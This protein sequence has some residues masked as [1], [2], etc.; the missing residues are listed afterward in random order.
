MS[1]IVKRGDGYALVLRPDCALAPRKY[2][3]HVSRIGGTS[4]G[5]GR[6]VPGFWSKV[7]KTGCAPGGCWEWIGYLDKDGYGKFTT[8]RGLDGV[9]LAKPRTFRPHRALWEHLRG[10]IPDDLYLLHNCDNARCVNPDHLRPGTQRENIVECYARGRHEQKGDNRGE[11]SG[12]AKLTADQVLFIRAQ[13]KANGV[14]VELSR[15]FGVSVCTLSQIRLR[16]SWKHIG[17]GNIANAMT[18]AQLRALADQRQ[19]E[20]ANVGHDADRD[21]SAQA[22]LF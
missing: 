18:V 15:L 7:K 14:L 13:R 10:P 5:I 9:K 21:L 8:S 11:L 1:D 22:R 4:G 2:E 19:R 20:I 12:T 16:R 6:G 17:N 3:R